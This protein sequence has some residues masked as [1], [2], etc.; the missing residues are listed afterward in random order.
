MSDAVIEKLVEEV[1]ALRA[2]VAALEVLEAPAGVTDHGELGGLGDDDH[3]HYLNTVRHGKAHKIADLTLASD[4]ASFTISNIP[5]T[6]AHLE[7][8][9]R[10]RW[11]TTN[12]GD[13]YFRCNGD[14]GAN[15]CTNYW[16]G[17]NSLGF[18]A[19]GNRSQIDAPST[20]PGTNL[21]ALRYSVI[22]LTILD[23]TLA[24]AKG[25]LLHC[26]GAAAQTLLWGQWQSS[27]SLTS[28][29]ATIV[30]GKL[31]AGAKATLYG[32]PT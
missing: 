18:G 28:I 6:F 22:R 1:V 17:N 26:G 12:Y 20:L 16:T 4:A 14:S 15:Y 2:R 9:V 3:L 5:Q 23:Y 25:F 27:D 30:S 31:V 29:T 19:V 21:D 24:I 7:L 13:L 8:L 10:A 32:Y 11:N